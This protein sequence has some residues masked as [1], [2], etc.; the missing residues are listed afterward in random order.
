[1]ARA[2]P[3]PWTTVQPCRS[4]RQRNPRAEINPATGWAH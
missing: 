1:V 3:V 4:A 2:N